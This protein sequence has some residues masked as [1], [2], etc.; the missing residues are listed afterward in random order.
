MTC[1]ARI[2]FSFACFFALGPIFSQ[3]G[4]WTEGQVTFFTSTNVYVRFAETS[5]ITVGDT[6]YIDREEPT[7]CLLISAISSTS[8]VGN[9]LNNC[10]LSKDNVVYHRSNQKITEPND[11]INT[12]T[13]DTTSEVQKGRL[14][15]IRGR[16][17][18]SSY[19]TV[20]EKYNSDHRMMYRLMFNAEHIADSK[21]SVS[22]YMNY[23]Q[24]FPKK[25]GESIR[26]RD[27]YRIYDL[28]LRYDVSQDMSITLGRKINSKASSLGAIDGV[29]AEKTFGRFLLGGLFGSRPDIGA[30]DLNTD[31]LEYGG[32]LGYVSD[33][34][35]FRS[36]SVLGLLQQNN[37]GAVD[38]RYL[39]FQHS[40][41][42]KELSLFSSGELDLY[43]SAAADTLTSGAR[44]TNLFVSARYRFSRKFDAYLSYDSRKRVVF[45]ETYKTQVE[46]LLEDDEA[47]QGVRLRLNYKPV[48]Y[49]AIRGSYSNRFQTSGENR[50][51][52]INLSVTWSRIASV[53]GRIAIY[54]NK[55][56]SNYMESD[57]FSIR[58][59]R[60]L[61]KNKL[62]IDLYFRTVNY[63]Y[64]SSG[65]GETVSR[66]YSQYFYGAGLSYN[67][68]PELVFSALGE[69]ST[70]NE[71]NFYRVNARIIKRF[72]YRK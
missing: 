41:S 37:Q 39:Y 34:P 43:S 54:Y 12:A 60:Q 6:L 68:M 5:S 69:Y 38:R 17:S 40:S 53:G 50:S 30:Y 63:L 36:T 72:R 25:Q 67:I 59:S 35:K 31:L 16:I 8:A 27:Q 44:L 24:L 14:Q 13:I 7:P 29:Q 42:I 18:A 33:D 23:T 9:V 49:V 21:F 61:V 20:S 56:M 52:N 62:D 48:K 1:T 2:I 46:R 15:N 32:Y 51:D 3:E 10:T 64:K 11:E 55:N 65:F 57:I 66:N 28:A 58:H 45:Y 47:R 4:E 26:Q 71:G 19:N 22:T 70:Q